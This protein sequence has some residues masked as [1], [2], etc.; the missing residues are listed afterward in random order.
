MRCGTSL[1]S[2]VAVSF[3][4]VGC[5]GSY[6]SPGGLQYAVPVITVVDATTGAAICDATVIVLTDAE[7]GLPDAASPTNTLTSS[8]ADGGPCVYAGAAL[9]PPPPGNPVDAMF[10]IQVSKAGY[11]TAT[12]PNVTTH[13]RA[14]TGVSVGPE[15]SLTHQMVNVQ[16]QPM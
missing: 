5:Q 8:A 1:I 12:V 15:T 4:S 6:C 7:A 9:D 2:G 3:L 11:K 16:L 14:C 13:V 10:T